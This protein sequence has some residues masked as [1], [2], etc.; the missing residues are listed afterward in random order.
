MATNVW[1]K[2]ALEK[3][4]QSVRV[5]VNGVGP[6]R[7]VRSAL[8]LTAAAKRSAVGLEGNSTRGLRSVLCDRYH[9]CTCTHVSLI[10][11]S[12]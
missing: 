7:L 5:L 6:G 1:L 12:F 3:G 4:V 9:T 8:F 2:G 10:V 11:I